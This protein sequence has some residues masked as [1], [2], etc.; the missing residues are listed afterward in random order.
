VYKRLNS[1][2]M[3]IQRTIENRLCPYITLLSFNLEFGNVLGV[4]NGSHLL[5]HPGRITPTKTYLLVQIAQP[6]EAVLQSVAYCVARR[7]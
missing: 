5:D 6:R 7:R 2:G 3:S 1:M 4:R